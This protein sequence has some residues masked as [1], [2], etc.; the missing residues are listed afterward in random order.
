[1]P[2]ETFA[3]LSMPKKSDRTRQRIIE[4]A[5]RL[6]Y[7][8]GYN[9]TSFT[10]IVEASG[11]PRGNIYYYF[12]TKEDILNASIDYRTERISRMLEDWSG[13]Y[14]TPMERLQR[15][16]H[17][18]DGNADTLS[19]Y[20]CPM[21]TLN[22]ELGKNQPELKARA[23]NLFKIFESWLSDQFSELGYAGQAHEL[24]LRFMAMGQGISML[25]HVHHD[26]SIVLRERKR[27]S[28]WID[29][30]AVGKD[31]CI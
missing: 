15:F 27:M 2:Y 20:G 24:A 5:N 31:D 30:L 4:S 13:S 7:Q 9:Q 6:F 10:D 3:Q 12:K 8:Q 17:I 28:Q 14:R 22:A 23:E 18:L 25:A 1:M 29:Q 26:S 16:T 21:G 11:V 19:N